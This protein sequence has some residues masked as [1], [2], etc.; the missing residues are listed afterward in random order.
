MRRALVP[1]LPLVVALCSA[2]SGS[3]D[4]S[5][6]SDDDAGNDVTITTDSNEPD[7]ATPTDSSAP[8]DTSMIMDTAPST[9]PFAYVGCGGGDIE[10]YAF[11]EATGTLTFKAKFAGGSNPSFLAKHPTRPLLYAVNEGSAQVAAFA[12]GAGGALSLLNR[13]SSSGNGPAF[14]SVEATGKYALVANY[15]GGTV[16]VLTIESDGKL[17]AKT[18]DDAPGPKAH[19]ILAG[20]GNKFVYAPVLGTDAVYQYAFNDAT[21]ALT[22]LSPARAMVASGAGPRHIA[23][24]PAGKYAFVVNELNDTVTSF[25]IESSG[26]LT[27]Q[28]SLSTLPMGTSGASNTGA[29][30][31]AHPNGKFLYS[32][33]RGHNSIAVF[34]VATDGKLALLENTSTGG[35][36]PRNFGLTP[37]ARVMLV[38]NQGSANVVTFAVD[39]ATGKL[40]K[41]KTATVCGSPSFVS[42]FDV[43]K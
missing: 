14:V 3:D 36:T 12:I 28:Q 32:S 18:D 4:S 17:G 8:A 41:L 29:D 16:A 38:A 35:S 40:T 42:V 30:I 26:V 10:Q 22:A 37:S 33:N 43:P 7:T 9:E 5:A 27:S 34:S 6:E 20:P 31:H 15:G 39:D 19:S 1:C 23:F 25:V 2:C 11:D 21:G 24:A 13:V